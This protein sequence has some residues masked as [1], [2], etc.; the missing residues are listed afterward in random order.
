M[1]TVA[2]VTDS[3]SYLPD[4]L[5]AR[6]GIR[7]VPLQVTVGTRTGTE[8]LDVTAAMVTRALRDRLFVT[9]SRPS[10]ADFA[11]AYRA[12]LAGGAS[13]VVSVHVSAALSGTWDSACL[14][15]QDFGY[16]TVRVVDSRSAAMALGFAVLAASDAALAGADPAAVQDAAVATVD[17]TRSVFYVDTL[18]YLRRGGRI[19]SAAALLATSLSVKPL[20]HVEGGRVVPLEKVR[21]SAKALTRL[22]ALTVD[23]CGSGPVDVAVHHLDAPER[24]ENVAAR[25]REQIPSL[26][27]L[28]TSEVGAVLGAHL[29]PG[30]VGTVVVRR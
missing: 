8:G 9:T 16:G 26:G 27:H 4:G 1:G 13:H 15:A 23:A 22:V 11:G 17:R 29:G 18:E 7:V 5:A 28:Y 3:T 2:V 21:T 19:G 25:L 6:L 14:A 12:A 20:L 10:P 30:M 24:A